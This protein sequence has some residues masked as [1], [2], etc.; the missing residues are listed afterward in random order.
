MA[1]VPNASGGSTA[2]AADDA[3]ILN[4]RAE[5]FIG[6]VPMALLAVTINACVLAW[7]LHRSVQTEW[8]AVWLGAIALLSLARL[9]DYRAARARRL[10]HERLLAHLRRAQ[11]GVLLSGVLW[12]AA[13]LFLFPADNVAHQAMLT[14]I[15]A[16]I[17]AGSVNTFSI[18]LPVCSGF[19]A[20]ALVPL[21][22]RM[23]S[24]HT[25]VGYAFALLTLLYFVLMLSIARRH[26]RTVLESLRLSR[27]R[28]CAEATIV[29]QAYYDPLTGLP[30][31]RLL[32]DRLQLDLARHAQQG[33]VGGLLF[34]DID[35]FQLINSSFGH[36][37]GNALIE[38]VAARINNLL[39]GAHTIARLEG[40]RFVVVLTELGDIPQAAAN[41]ARQWAE[42]LRR[43]LAIPL[44]AAGQEIQLS[45]SVGVA[46]FP[47]DGDT[48]DD[49]LRAAESALSQAKASGRDCISFYLPLIQAAAK[50]RM[51]MEGAL[52]RALRD[53]DLTLHY[54]PQCD[55]T[56]RILTAEA[57]IRWPRADGADMVAS[58][59]VFVP[60][61]EDSGLIHELGEWVI[62]EALRDIRTL[63]Q[64]LGAR[65]PRRIAL[66]VSPVQFREADFA[67]TLAARLRSEQLDP[68]RLELEITEHVL[69]ANFREIAR[70]MDQLRALGVHFSVD[71]FGTGYSSLSY[72]KRLPLDA[73]KID[74][75]FVRDV[76]RDSSDATIVETIIEMAHRL[77]L[78]V[79][80]EGVESP[81]VKTFL[82]QRGC[83]LYQGFLLYQP[84]PLAAL[85]AALRKPG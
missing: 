48:P 46:L 6:A 19:L 42:N 84:M 12:G 5:L 68:G 32:C 17:T 69:V 85:I 14:V 10:E 33:K 64:Q 16:G 58:P 7:F 40:D 25:E 45:I 76:A 80:A 8:V 22:A 9:F 67:A 55:R 63:E 53:G 24:Q 36:L 39:G 71:D 81:E 49:L 70:K 28:D 11:L 13:S 78:R 27:A 60:M 54:Q 29:Q 18:F 15:L 56:G 51:D 26:Q 82:E 57:L 65:C 30:N 47:D 75:S 23:L 79:V 77:G 59:G 73:L 2:A 3:R 4:Q 37:V 44:D 31:R 83:D 62:S 38:A 41:R 50:A 43:V 61:A 21:F 66:N 52:R 34:L 35:R 1:L 72:L 74:R 20:L